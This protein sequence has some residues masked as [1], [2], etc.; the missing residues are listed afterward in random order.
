M[1]DSRRGFLVGAAN[2]IGAGLTLALVPNVLARAAEP[3]LWTPEAGSLITD[4][5]RVWSKLDAVLP[6]GP[7]YLSVHRGD[8]ADP[9]LQFSLGTNGG[10]RYSTGPREGLRFGDGQVLQEISLLTRI[11]RRG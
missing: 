3:L 2:V 7:L 9:A 10:L 4:R 6:E 8:P 11:K 5:H 1:I